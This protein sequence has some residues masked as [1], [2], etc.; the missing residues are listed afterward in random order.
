M[1]KLA[2]M[3]VSVATALARELVAGSLCGHNRLGLTIHVRRA[4][5]DVLA[6]ESQQVL[7]ASNFDRVV[8]VSPLETDF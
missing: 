2:C 1:C 4:C 3:C 6:R 5:V 7:K 8:R